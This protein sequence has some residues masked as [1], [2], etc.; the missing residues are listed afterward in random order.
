M[1]CAED[2]EDASRAHI[3]N[4]QVI[5]NTSSCSEASPRIHTVVATMITSID[6]SLKAAASKEVNAYNMQQPHVQHR[7]ART[8]TLHAEPCSTDVYMLYCVHRTPY[9]HHNNRAAAS[10]CWRPCTVHVKA[11]ASKQKPTAA[12]YLTR[13]SNIDNSTCC[14]ASRDFHCPKYSMDEHTVPCQVKP[15]TQQ[16]SS[17]S[18]HAAVHHCVSRRVLQLRK[19]NTLHALH[20]TAKDPAHLPPAHNHRQALA[21]LRHQ[22]A[23]PRPSTRHNADSVRAETVKYLADAMLSHTCMHA[24]LHQHSW[25]ITPPT[26]AQRCKS[27]KNLNAIL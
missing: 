5:T 27:R 20:A 24:M 21:A 25:W 4:R 16:Q 10:T 17:S 18:G 3:T 9:C 23:R 19:R 14:R 6:S 2:A 7:Q 13:T 15:Q 26:T 1:L 12:A 22:D 11:N 8:T